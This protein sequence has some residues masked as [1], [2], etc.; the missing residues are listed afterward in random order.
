MGADELH[1]GGTIGEEAG[2]FAEIVVAR[3]GRMAKHAVERA[4]E[5]GGLLQRVERIDEQDKAQG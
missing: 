2:V 3:D 1:V 5:T 4:D